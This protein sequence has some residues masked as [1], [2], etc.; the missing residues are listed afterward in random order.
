[1]LLRASGT[2]ALLRHA[3]D[4]VVASLEDESPVRTAAVRELGD[5][6]PAAAPAASRSRGVWATGL[7]QSARRVPFAWLGPEA[8]SARKGSSRSSTIRI[9]TY[10]S[11][12]RACSS[13]LA[14]RAVRR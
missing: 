8:R 4:V 12:L 2:S 3:F 11:A 7:P 5:L 13:A 6:G 14:Q 1:M 9:P 10:V